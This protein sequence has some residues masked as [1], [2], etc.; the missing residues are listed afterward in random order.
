MPKYFIR[1]INGVLRSSYTEF[2]ITDKKN[3]IED[4]NSNERYIQGL[5]ISV[6]GGVLSGNGSI[7]I[8]VLKMEITNIRV[9]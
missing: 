4:D 6:G 1:S 5:E 9:S 8:R 2:E 3:L 7:L